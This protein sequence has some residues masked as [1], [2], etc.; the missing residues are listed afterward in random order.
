VTDEPDPESAYAL[1]AGLE[2]KTHDL[3]YGD[4]GIYSNNA[5]LSHRYDIARLVQ[6]WKA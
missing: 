5:D 4:V 3:A 2:T 6:F 1:F